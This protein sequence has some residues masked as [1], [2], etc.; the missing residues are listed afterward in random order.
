MPTAAVA[1]ACPPG[2]SQY[3]RPSDYRPRGVHRMSWDV[4]VIAVESSPAPKNAPPWEKDQ[5]MHS[6]QHGTEPRKD[7]DRSQWRP[8][9]DPAR[10]PASWGAGL[11]LARPTREGRQEPP[12]PRRARP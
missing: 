5:K 11:A 1:V 6:T 7:S 10:G 12:W 8:G 2:L 3:I 4:S 9:A